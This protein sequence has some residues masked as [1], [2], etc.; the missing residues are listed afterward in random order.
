MLRTMS[1]SL[2]PKAR[3]TCCGDEDLP[4]SQR[5]TLP[6]PQPFPRVVV[7]HVEHARSPGAY[8]FVDGEAREDLRRRR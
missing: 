2:E 7:E 5:P 1:G 6:S 8:R 4:Q 3:N